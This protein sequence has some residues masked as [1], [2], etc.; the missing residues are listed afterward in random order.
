M[1]AIGRSGLLD[2]KNGRCRLYHVIQKN[3][4]DRHGLRAKDA[5][6]LYFEG[7]HQT[8]G[9]VK[10]KKKIMFDLVYLLVYTKSTIRG[11]VTSRK[12]G[13]HSP[14]LVPKL[15]DPWLKG[16]LVP[17]HSKMWAREH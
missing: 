12:K 2:Q 3:G 15:F 6:W 9:F 1:H 16:A 14:Q 17:V 5:S 10:L 4:Q 8:L 11:Y 7:L 13:F